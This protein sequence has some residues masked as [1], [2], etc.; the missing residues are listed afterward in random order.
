[1]P[2]CSKGN[3]NVLF[4][5]LVLTGF[6]N[7]LAF[8]NGMTVRG[9]LSEANN[10]PGGGPTPS[11]TFSFQDFDAV[12][13]SVNDLFNGG[14]AFASF[15]DQHLQLPPAT[16]AAAPEIDPSTALSGMTL[17]LGALAALCARVHIK[18]SWTLS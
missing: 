12:L 1:M 7:D 10:V 16:T 5:N 4:G 6:T 17:H 14:P 2:A 13:L 9:L 18:R 3:S 15:D 8:L 11:P